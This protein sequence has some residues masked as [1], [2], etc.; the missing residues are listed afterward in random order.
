VRGINKTLRGWSVSGMYVYVFV[1]SSMTVFAFPR[2]SVSF[3]VHC[4]LVVYLCY[5]DYIGDTVCE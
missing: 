1:G 4:Q 3:I 5:H 2:D